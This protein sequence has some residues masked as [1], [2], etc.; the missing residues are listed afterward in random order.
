MEF[1]ETEK[2]GIYN[3]AFDTQAADDAIIYVNHDSP[4]LTSVK[5]CRLTSFHQTLKPRIVIRIRCTTLAFGIRLI[6]VILSSAP[7]HFSFTGQPRLQVPL[8]ENNDPLTYGQL[9]LDDQI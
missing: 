1:C 3:L 9:F 8:A 4:I 2:C 7:P 5:I 6:R